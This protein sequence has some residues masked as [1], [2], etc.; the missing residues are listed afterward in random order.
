MVLRGVANAAYHRDAALSC[1]G[2]KRLLRSPWHYWAIANATHAQI[3]PP[4]PAMLNGTLVHCALLEPDQWD[5][6]YMVAPEGAD[7]RGKVYR[8][9]SEY[10]RGL[11][12][13]VIT[14]EAAE[15]AKAQ[16][17]AL[18]ELPEVARLMSRGQAEC[19][20]YWTDP[21][22]GVRCKCRPDFAAEGW[23]DHADSC[24]LLDVKTSRDASADGF[25]R[26]VVAYGYHQQAEWY[27]DGYARASGHPVLGMV[28]V[29]VESDFPHAAAAYEL[30]E[31]A[32]QL[33]RAL[34]MRARRLYAQC[35]QQGQWPSYP[36]EIVR[37]S[38]PAWAW[39][40][41]NE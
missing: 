8:N 2:A 11:G 22:T 25:A 30:D 28:F 32:L 15:R 33:G 14:W 10:A 21:M 24:I 35:Q 18:R 38:L 16:A 5:A 36:R 23:G 3:P 13:Q 40:E 17:Q 20:A 9:L 7:P 41:P 27:C 1:S 26:A 29:V 34:N 37:L 6:R 19:S 39:K 12:M 4:T 31:A